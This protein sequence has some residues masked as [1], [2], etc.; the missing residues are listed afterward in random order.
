MK[1]RLPATTAERLATGLLWLFLLGFGWVNLLDGGISIKGRNGHVAY[2][3]GNAG[4]ALA[5]GTFLLAA[6]MSLLL[7][8]TLGLSRLASWLLVL[9]VLAPPL[10]FV[11]FGTAG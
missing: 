5:V 2:A 11:L 9:A 8:R 10:L 4:L 6:L 1:R 7:A 3:S